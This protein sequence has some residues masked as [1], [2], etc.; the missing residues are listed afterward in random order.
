[1]SWTHERATVAALKRRRPSD[2]PEVVTAVG[3]LKAAR[4]E[5]YIKQVVDQAPPL[6]ADQRARIAVVLLNGGA[7]A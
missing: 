1:M 5:D 2:D 4:L 7:A 3:N 6:S